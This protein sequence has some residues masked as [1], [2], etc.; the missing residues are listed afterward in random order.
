MLK[1]RQESKVGTRP[2][3]I[4]PSSPSYTFTVIRRFFVKN[5]HAS[6]LILLSNDM[7]ME[8]LFDYRDYLRFDITEQIPWATSNESELKKLKERAVW[9]DQLGGSTSR[10]AGRYAKKPFRD[11]D[12]LA[13]MEVD[14]EAR[15]G[16]M[17]RVW[18]GPGGVTPLW[19][20]AV[21]LKSP[22]G[23]CG[24]LSKNTQNCKL[25]NQL[26]MYAEFDKIVVSIYNRIFDL[27]ILI[28]GY[29]LLM[30]ELHQFKTDMQKE[31]WVDPIQSTLNGQ[32]AS[33]SP[34]QSASLEFHTCLQKGDFFKNCRNQLLKD[35][36]YDAPFK[37]FL[38]T[39]LEQFRTNFFEVLLHW[40][41]FLGI[42]MMMVAKDKTAYFSTKGDPAKGW[43]DKSSK[44]SQTSTKNREVTPEME[45]RRA[46][47]LR[48]YA[49]EMSYW[50]E[51][52][53]KNFDSDF[54]LGD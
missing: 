5:A 50:V 26:G 36:K 39:S 52:R 7:F 30:A 20:K 10:I 3:P 45:E 34:L 1:M 6:K 38:Q 41:Q 33:T 28:G 42:V 2:S 15:R 35:I 54:S 13:G 9:E 22:K 48:V 21:E 4:S 16:L 17:S 32:E 11:R 43:R 51:K 12:K 29:P 40:R 37:K 18:S 27:N 46:M 49:K 8:R 31:S 53:I 25:M 24:V 23:G 14:A 19:K 44:T 47:N